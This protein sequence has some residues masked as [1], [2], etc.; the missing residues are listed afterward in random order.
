MQKR[1]SIGL[2]ALVLGTAAGCSYTAV[3]T[4]SLASRPDVRLINPNDG[5]YSI[6]V[7]LRDNGRRDYSWEINSRIEQAA[8]CRV[9]Y[10]KLYSTS[11]FMVVEGNIGDAGRSYPVVLDTGASQSIFV[12]DTHVLENKLAIY[13]MQTGKVLQQSFCKF[14]LL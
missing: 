12:K 2:L 13:P 7:T 6:E 14:C 5:P 4:G 8:P 9:K 3:N 11:R 1:L 10:H